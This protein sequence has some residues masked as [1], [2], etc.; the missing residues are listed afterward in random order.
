MSD[1]L[2]IET[3]VLDGAR[4][5][6]DHAS[7]EDVRYRIARFDPP[8]W[9][10]L[11]ETSQALGICFTGDARIVLVTWSGRDWSLPGGTPRAR[12]DPRAGARTRREQQVHRLP[13]GR[14]A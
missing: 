11:E 14:G 13:T 8:F 7:A 4:R 10:P 2:F 5:V 6:P 1:P 9:P 12:R 3:F